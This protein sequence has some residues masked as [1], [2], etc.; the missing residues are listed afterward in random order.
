MKKTKLISLLSI[1]FGTSILTSCSFNFKTMSFEFGDG[2][3]KTQDTTKEDKTSD[4]TTKK[5]DE[6]TTTSKYKT[7]TKNT[8]YWQAYTKKNYYEEDFT[9]KTVAYQ[10]VMTNVEL[11]EG[12]PYN[13]LIN[14]Y[15]DGEFVINQYYTVKG[16]QYFDYYGY[17]TNMNDENLFAVTT[18]YSNVGSG[19]VN[20]IDYSYSL[21][22]NGDGFDTFGINLALGFAEG[23][24]YVRN[25]DV[26]GNGE[27]V[28][29]TV[30]DYEKTLN[31]TRSSKPDY[32]ENS[33]QDKD[34]DK[35][36]DS[37]STTDTTLF[38]WTSDSENYTLKFNKDC[39]YVFEFKTAK[40][41]ENG[42]WSFS[43][44][45]LKIVNSNNVEIAATMDST[46]HAFSLNYVSGISELVTR[47][48]TV[49]SSVWGVA[50]GTS[51][52]YTAK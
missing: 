51:G 38:T 5:D 52:S 33:S 12:R 15:E 24:V 31:V 46:S 50:L 3:N 23:G 1:I 47:T 10:F 4:N 39:T 9:T 2:E 43:N 42:T 26:I 14:L 6:T 21:T 40:L 7:P 29:K 18:C 35:K 20:G 22:K 45:E 28:Y 44:W 25:R 41:V 49:D 17:W 11:N 27:V 34:D 13:V 30:A 48:F 19:I 8:D 36:D 32:E 16:V 37:S